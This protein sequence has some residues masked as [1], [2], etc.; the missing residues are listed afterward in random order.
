H[1]VVVEL[2]VE[3]MEHAM[4]HS[5]DDDAVAAFESEML[6]FDVAEFVDTYREERDMHGDD[7]PGY[8]RG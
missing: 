6:D 7:V 8:E 5:R 3:L 2:T 1:E 4:S